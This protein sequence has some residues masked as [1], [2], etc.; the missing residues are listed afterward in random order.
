[1]SFKKFS[2]CQR[3]PPCAPSCCCQQPSVCGQHISVAINLRL[4]R[5]GG[6]DGGGPHNI[7]AANTVNRNSGGVRKYPN[8]NQGLSQVHASWEL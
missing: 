6:R 1:M 3:V 7:V 2:G 5:T 8:Q 4:L